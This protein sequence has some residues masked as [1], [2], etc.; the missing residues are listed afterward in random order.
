MA[1]RMAWPLTSLDS[2]HPVDA[3]NGLGGL[4]CLADLGLDEHVHG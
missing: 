1:R 4:A 3:P 2:L